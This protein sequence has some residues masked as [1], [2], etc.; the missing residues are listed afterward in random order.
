MRIETRS[1]MRTVGDHR[2][3]WLL[4]AGNA[5]ATLERS[6]SRCVAAEQTGYRALSSLLLLKPSRAR[7]LLFT[8]KM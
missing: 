3:E 2:L 4:S 5:A 1:D 6:S 7:G 8:S